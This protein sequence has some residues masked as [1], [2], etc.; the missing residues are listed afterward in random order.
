[1]AKIIEVAKRLDRLPP[2]LFVEIDKA[3]REARAE[4]R[5]II[6]LGIGD[7]DGAT[8]NY[9]IESLHQAS[10][11]PKNHR[12]ALDQGM[13]RL[14]EAIA[15]WYKI[16]F[17]VSLDSETEILPLI[18][19]KEGIAHMPLA[20]VNS[21]DYVLTPDPCYPPYKT[22]TILADGNPYPM[23]LKKENMFN[24]VL[25]DIPSNIRRKSKILYINYPNNPTSGIVKNGFFKEVVKF[26]FYHDVIICHD[27]AY[28]EV[29]YDGYK[30]PSFLQTDGAKEIGV[31][32]NSL[33]KPYNM[34]GWR[35]GWVCGSA[36]I[37]AALA[38]VKSNI[39]SGIFSA[40]QI[41]GIT[42]L[43]GSDEHIAKMNRIYQERRDVFIS[44]LNA[45]GFKI[46]PP[47][48]TFY[49]WAS[50]PKKYNS[51]KFAKLLLDKCDIVVTPGVGF[52]KY[53]EGYVRFALTVDKSI[54]QEALD[55]IKNKLG[56]V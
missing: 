15:K 42:A 31:E 32:F 54:I 35:I 33:S 37:I 5:N 14:R 23:P 6:D 4:G 46:D 24:P 56:S 39:D 51:I 48:A 26:G 16:R 19:S 22:G 49:V 8:P 30:A 52:G 1:M 47:K 25:K 18:G 21:G 28:S 50:I 20:F 10:K 41:A 11:D 43:E 29:T 55:R 12:Y 53:G 45:L 40:I 38:N 17:N 27:A 36:K 34:T 3:K 7:P 9:I 2:Y 44:G 13:P